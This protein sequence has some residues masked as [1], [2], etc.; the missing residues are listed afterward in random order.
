MKH[1]IFALGLASAAAVL[2]MPAHAATTVSYPSGSVIDLVATPDGQ[3][4]AGAF[5]ASITGSGAF[6]TTYTFSVPSP[7]TISIAGI[8]I[9]SSVLSNIDFTSGF[10]NGTTPFMVSN[11]FVDLAELAMQP[12][13]AG[14][15]S[16][17]LNGTLNSN[18][19]NG[20]AA[21]GGNVSFALAPNAVP[22]PATWALF[23]LGFGV[24]GSSLR[25]RSARSTLVKSS[26][27]FA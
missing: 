26:I 14:Q 22:E 6:S 25:R 12:L 20:T 18:G 19:R 9:L 3:T 23:I 27:K 11:G 10:L 24:I 8:S 1:G 21:I 16:F 15:H 7:G 2:A 17:T 13:G 4:L 5:T